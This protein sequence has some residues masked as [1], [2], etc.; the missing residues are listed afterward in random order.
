[1]DGVVAPFDQTFPDA[2]DE[3]STTLPPEQK[4]V[5]PP[6]VTVGTA[7]IGFTVTTV[8]AEFAEV[9]GPLVTLTV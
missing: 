6:G 4:V 2:D 7:G 9:Q 5:G 3:V 1:M 8:A